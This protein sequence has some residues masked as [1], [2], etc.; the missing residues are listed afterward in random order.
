MSACQADDRPNIVLVTL[1]T[2]RADRIGSMGDPTAR[3]PTLDSLAERGAIFERC[4][5][6]APLT[7][8]SH[9]TILTGLD[10]SRHGVRNNGERVAPEV[11]TVAEQL[12]RVGYATAAFVAAFVLD[13]SFGLDQGFDTYDDEIEFEGDPLK[14]HVPQRDGA[15]VT[16]SVLEWLKERA[17]R[18]FFLWVHY[19]DVHTPRD[20]PPPFDEMKDDYAGE[21]AYVDAQVA[22]LLSGVQG[23]G[24][25]RKTLVIVV[26][27]H[28]ES[29]GE[30][31]EATHGVVAY[32]STLQ[33]PLIV[34]G[35]GFPAGSRSAS[36]CGTQDV[37]PTILAAV[38]ASPLPKSKGIPLQRLIASD[39][40]PERVVYFESHGPALGFGW[41]PLSGVRDSRWKYTAEP[42]PVELY[43]TLTDPGE[44][45]NRAAGEPEVAERLQARFASGFG[46]RPETEREN[47]RVSPEVEQ[48]LAE[49][50]YVIAPQHFAPGKA[51][52]P[53]RFVAA[54][55]WIDSARG[56]ALEG[57]VADS[58]Q[59]LEILAS[60]PAVRT[61]ALRRLAQV[62]LAA[63]RPGDAV[64][65][66]E[67]L[68]E[69]SPTAELRIGLADALL[70]DGRAENALAALEGMPA[71]TGGA[72]AR[73]QL[74]RGRA[75][76]QANRI[77]EASGVIDVILASDPLNE[78]ALVLASQLRSQQDGA[79]AEIRHL[80][81]WL[82]SAPTGRN[83]ARLRIVLAEL[84]L[85]KRRNRE[86]IR[87][88]EEGPPSPGT[89]GLIAEIATANGNLPK[90]AEHYEAALA[91]RP[92]L[93]GYRNE[94][95]HLYGRLGRRK[96]A[97]ALYDELVAADPD[98]P[99]LLLERGSIRFQVGQLGEAESDFRRAASLDEGLPEA[100]L[101]VALVALRTGRAQEAEARLLRA[102]ELRPGYAKANFHLAH[103]YR[104]RGD[105]RAA[106]YA[107]RAAA[108]GALALA[109]PISERR[110]ASGA[111][112]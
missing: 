93:Q 31:D 12:G 96:E 22:R 36:L 64:A 67:E 8:P 38:G 3:T 85:E 72:S 82:E 69:M 4:F 71:E 45:L 40:I 78:R 50:G 110:G 103:L 21:L 46:A 100:Q 75:L 87:V 23:A 42:L 109:E 24:G 25:D 55:G 48:R 59:A 41:A 70:Q 56:L 102:L 99:R 94:L 63:D 112:Q 15:E 33:V 39:L 91:E 58:I 108:S 61:I 88:L 62:Y 68:L 52:D 35:P 54:L 30:H 6:S 74:L 111:I 49:L 51:P 80:A 95:A 76:L 29:L 9:T 83:W 53:R 18:P 17:R 47:S 13:S 11:E 81:K 107:E 26:A 106:R 104:L 77:A 73:T 7:L 43:D 105:P 65:T 10:P 79:E 28:G 2:T 90:A 66:F 60:S 20:P 89:H 37:A 44:T 32:D 34:A 57:R 16:D 27:D 14:P 86:A 1:D 5:A 97:L 84:L 101:N 19:Y 98:H 92:A